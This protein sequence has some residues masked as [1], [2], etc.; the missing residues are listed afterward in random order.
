MMQLL[1]QFVC[2]PWLPAV[3]HAFSICDRRL[4]A[5][6]SIVGALSFYSPVYP[7]VL[8]SSCRRHACWEICA[9]LA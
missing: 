8:A 4:H 9:S 6:P 5:T 3:L 1:L 7:L 2:C